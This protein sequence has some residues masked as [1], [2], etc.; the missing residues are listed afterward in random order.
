MDDLS[1]DIEGMIAATLAG[2]DHSIVDRMAVN[3]PE[4][5]CGGMRVEKF[6]M[7]EFDLNNLR[8]AMRNSRGTRPG[9]Y[10]RLVADNDFWMS[11]VDAEKLDHWPAVEKISSLKARRVLINGLGLGMVVQAAL[12][13]D[14]VEH[15]DV[16]EQ[17]ERV[18]KLVSPTYTDP[19][20]TIHHAD[21]YDQMKA[22]PRGTKWDVGWSDIWPEII[23]DNLADMERFNRSYAQRC[24]WHECWGQH[25]ARRLRD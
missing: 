9:T 8:E 7:G 11:D 19:R 6:T 16:V 5:E 12:S 3:V 2:V 4:G 18:I 24:Q 13:F 20:V 15:I 10:T 23:P 1:C 14:H 17:D 25:I 22:W 21:A